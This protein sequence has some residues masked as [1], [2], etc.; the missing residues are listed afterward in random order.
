MCRGCLNGCRDKKAVFRLRVSLVVGKIP[1]QFSFV[2][3]PILSV[4]DFSFHLH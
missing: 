3:P 1:W 2:A 4:F